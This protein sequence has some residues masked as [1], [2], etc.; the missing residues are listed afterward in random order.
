MIPAFNPVR[1]G[2]QEFRGYVS[3]NVDYHSH[4]DQTGVFD[5]WHQDTI[6]DDEGY[7]TDLITRYGLDFLDRK[8]R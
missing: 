2:F 6:T 4:I 1:Q 3:G 5:W 8:G 7:S